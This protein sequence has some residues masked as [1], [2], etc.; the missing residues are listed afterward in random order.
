[1]YNNTSSRQIRVLFFHNSVP[2]YRIAFWEELATFVDLQICIT[3]KGLDE[4]I[5]GL[6]KNVGNLKI[7]YLES[8][9]CKVLKQLI[10]KADVII[11][12]PCDAPKEWAASIR[13]EKICKK[14]NNPYVF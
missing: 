1:M 10:D 9:K 12:P 6:E 11:L 2:E 14:Q 4:K 5:Y 8:I 7:E 3:N 13:I